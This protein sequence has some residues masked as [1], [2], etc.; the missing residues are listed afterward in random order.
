VNSPSIELAQVVAAIAVL[1]LGA[2]LFARSWSARRRDHPDAPL[3]R[4]SYWPVT[5][6]EFTVLMTMI[7]CLGVLGQW[8]V[9]LLWGKAI[10]ISSERESLTLAAYGAG[11][12][13][14]ALLGWPLFKLFQRR[15]HFESPP[16]PEPVAAL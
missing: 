15:F 11:F 10:Q 1:A 14:F 7:I 3:G 12:H 8:I 6:W 9:S 16:P 4:L 13:G 5:G 2:W